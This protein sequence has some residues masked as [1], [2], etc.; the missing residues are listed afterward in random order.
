MPFLYG[1]SIKSIGYTSTQFVLHSVC[2]T[3]T[4]HNFFSS[5]PYSNAG[6]AE[7]QKWKNHKFWHCPIANLWRYHDKIKHNMGMESGTTIIL[8]STD[9]ALIRQYKF[10][11]LKKCKLNFT[12]RGKFTWEK[13]V[14]IHCISLMI[15][16]L[17]QIKLWNGKRYSHGS[18]I[19]RFSINQRREMHSIWKFRQIL[20]ICKLVWMRKRS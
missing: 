8:V 2:T 5:H 16:A 11:S 19:C 13:R 10:T 1:S 14:Q 3:Q 7:R 6:D 18:G 4:K 20:D 15:I 9:S 12:Y 17:K